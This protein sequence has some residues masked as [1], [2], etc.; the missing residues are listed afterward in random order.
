MSVFGLAVG[1]AGVTRGKGSSPLNGLPEPSLPSLSPSTAFI[2]SLH[3]SAP[4]SPHSLRVRQAPSSPPQHFLQ[5]PLSTSLAPTL[6]PLSIPANPPLSVQSPQY[7]SVTYPRSPLPMS[8]THSHNTRSPP[9]SNS[10]VSSSSSGTLR[11]G[12][13]ESVSP[14]AVAS[15]NSLPYGNRE[16]LPPWLMAEANPKDRDSGL[17]D[18]LDRD[19]ARS[20][21]R[22]ADIRKD[23]LE[24]LGT[25]EK[26]AGAW[27]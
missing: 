10:M 9:S 15:P 11:G 12:R 8:S 7:S 17:H 16:A 27:P 2:A 20:K 25:V 26:I 3:T 5:P 1:D 4:H 21:E 18:A 6:T 13:R 19:R 24:L 14:G 23:F 22:S